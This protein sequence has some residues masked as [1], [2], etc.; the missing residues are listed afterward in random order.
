VT[1]I[2]P[3][4]IFIAVAAISIGAIGIGMVGC[5]NGRPPGVADQPGDNFI[6]LSDITAELVVGSELKMRVH[7]KFADDLPH[8]DAWF[9]FFF[10]V[11]DGKSGAVQIRKQGRELAEE[12]DIDASTSA[13]FLKR[14]SIRVRAKVMQGKSKNGPWHDVSD[15]SLL[16]T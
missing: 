5:G 16:D 15:T 10:E 6:E 1:G 13:M 14:T 7:Y 4:A 2:T 8:P 12:G 3:R 11:N 9:L